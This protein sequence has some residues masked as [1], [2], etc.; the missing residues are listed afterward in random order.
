M[1][2][3]EALTSILTLTTYYEST[4]MD[5]IYEQVIE[6]WDLER[7]NRKGVRYYN[8][9]CSFDIETTSFTDEK[10]RDTGLMYVW[11]LGIGGWCI[12]G[13]TWEE[14]KVC[15]ERLAFLFGCDPN[16]RL[17]IYVHNLAYEFQFMRKFFK[18]ENVFALDKRTPVYAL[19]E[20][21]IEFRC[22]YILSGYK[23]SKTAENLTMFKIRKLEGD[24]DYSLPRHA[25]TPLTDQEI[26]YCLN[27]VK[28]V[29]ADIYERIQKS[30]GIS[31]IPLTKT[32]YVRDYVRKACFKGV[33]GQKSNGDRLIYMNFI[34]KLSLEPDEYNTLKRAFAGGF[35]HANAFAVG[36][37]IKNIK[38]F[39]FTSSYPTVMIAERFPMSKGK[40]V[41]VTSLKELEQYCK[42]YCCVFDIG[43]KNLKP[44]FMFENYISYSRCRQPRNCL[45]NNGRI[46]SA[47]SVVLTITDVD[48]EILKYIYTW[49]EMYVGEIYYYRRGYLPRDI[50]MAILTLYN[51]KTKYKD[52]EGKEAEYANS[53]EN[54]NA[55]Y[56]MIV[57]DIVREILG[58]DDEWLDPEQPDLD[59]AINEYNNN[60]SRFLFYPWGVWVTAYARRNLFS[61]ILEFREDYCYS[62][63]DSLKV[64]NADKHM[65]YING[66][67]EYIVNKLYRTLDYYNLDRSLIHPMT[68]KGEV[69][70][71][72]IWDLDGVYTRFKT[73]GAKRY[74]YE[75][76][77]GLHI[78]VSG[79]N[80]GKAVPYLLER[81]GDKVFDEF[82][83]G[84]SI[85]GEYTGVLTHK[86]FDEER[87]GI[88]VD[89]LGNACEYEVP[90]GIHL[91]P[92]PYTLG[93]TDKFINYILNIQERYY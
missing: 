13:R 92:S 14:F 72:G 74:M 93:L 33:D 69:K 51:E 37:T 30:S 62:D 31:K 45:E 18:W 57:T 82:K 49:D 59:K 80:K 24:L 20:N 28:I 66:Y 70:T 42:D 5:W 90:S 87:A 83:N 21:G 8:I 56:G 48:Y 78:T 27:D 85:D 36:R 39:D 88:L 41:K 71:L 63:T 19:L 75:D 6:Q 38:S 50:I 86:Y 1:L 52:V 25:E 67:N 10:G 22:S 89:Y 43:F 79:L 54:I 81:Y 91:S 3:V 73:L 84:M 17:I 26:Q 47:D 61:G 34:R 15:I 16:T 44:K 60:K 58:Y 9:P 35:T 55:C 4:Q 53:K 76:K 7:A 23:L 2:S 32:G 77:K 46:V 12:I 11:T 68:V 29:M 64:E 40:K 65:E